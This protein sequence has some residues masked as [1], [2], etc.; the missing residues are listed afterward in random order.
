[1]AVRNRLVLAILC[2]GLIAGWL[3]G[4]GR[5]S[6]TDVRVASAATTIVLTPHLSGLSQPLAMT[7]P[8]DG[9]NR[10]FVVERTG[11]IRVSVNGA[12][13]AT[14]FL[15]VTSLIT[16]SN[17]EQGL[18]G[19]AFHPNY[20]S[21]GLFFVYYTAS[22]GDNTLARFHVS[23]GNA[24]Q[25]DPNSRAVL[26]AEADRFSNHNGGN[27]IFGPDGFL[28]VGLGDG[29]SA[30]DPDNN[31]QNLGVLLGKLL[32]I[33]V[34]S[35]S[36]YAIPSS[37]PF[38]NTPGARGE[39]WALG[40]RN[41]W[42]W[43]FDR[44]AGD[45]MIGD[46]GQGSWE[47]VDR[48]LRNAP[49]GAN[50]QWSCLEGTHPFS[51]RTCDQGTSTGP[52]FEYDHSQGEC[53]VTGGYMYRGSAIP[54]LFGQ[55][56]FS[57]YCSGRIWTLA[58]SGGTWSRMLLLDTP[59]NVASFA[60]DRNGEIY[61]IDITGGTVYRINDGGTPPTNT[62]TP[63]H[64]PV[65]AATN[66]PTRTP[67]PVAA[68]TNTPTRTPTSVAAATNTPTRTP[69][70]VTGGDA[71]SGTI[72][73]DDRPGQ[74]QPLTGEYPAGVVDW[75]SGQW[76]HSGPYAGFSTKSVGFDGSS[77]TS[78]T[79]RFI[80]PR[81][82]VRFD[83][84]NGGTASSALTASCPGQPTL[85]GNASPGQVGTLSTGWTGTCSSVTMTSSNGWD[86]NFDNIVF[87]TPGAAAPTATPTPTAGS[88]PGTTVTF[89]DL[90]SPNR[91]LNG[92]Y[93]SGSI[94][95]G[96]NAWYLSGPWRQFTTNSIG[97]NGSGP[98]SGSFTFVGAVRRLV[99][100]D[101]L[102]GGSGVSTI[103]LSCAG[104]RTASFTLNAGELRTLST[105]WTG[106]CPAVT[107]TSS[108]GW[109]TNF[110]NLVFDTP[111]ADLTITAFN[112][113]NGTTSQPPHLTFTVQNQGTADAGP[114]STFDIHVFADL[115]RPP[116]P[117]DIAYVAHIPVNRLDPGDSATVQGDVFSDTLQPGTHTLWALV[118]G[119]DTVAESNETNNVGS[120]TVTVTQGSSGTQNVTFDDLT[121]PNRPLSGQYPSGVI[122]W[123]TNVWYLSG[124]WRQF[125]TNSIGFNG[126]GP[127]SASF[128]F[129]GSSRRLVQIDAFNGGAVASTVG[130]SCA[131]QATAQFTVAAGQLMTLSTGWT[132]TCTSVT[133]SSTNGWDTN[134]DNLV[135]TQ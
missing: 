19:L 48:Q 65:A 59:Y 93:P 74:D 2:F 78:A 7:Q 124:P 88:A 55:Y 3:L 84:A 15:D 126:S 30:G 28:Y 60:E 117:A 91:A 135:I 129:V 111:N 49:G 86:T 100:I 36:P 22:N 134:F 73:F 25:A 110:D 47:E 89:N 131:G 95:W 40:L 119:H 98:T 43:S 72:S 54:S 96:T 16:S 38:V 34:N 133:V 75:G 58:Q 5:T 85:T 70:P 21:N 44:Q 42:R 69:T 53:S 71:S 31:A 24:N 66:T 122:D 132:G 106:T 87:D 113:T 109:N 20:A 128:T 79:F 62:P 97:F 101:T 90:D 6:D 123:G 27:V 107:V 67:T 64:T 80:T 81:R 37:N 26:F 11:R 68:A 8:N 1:M 94:D 116:T 103:T 76:F 33:D 121:N 4:V 114:G 115:G 9:T 52:I 45:L 56:V 102:N 17:S 46:V 120:V 41:P 35:G 12:L 83:F 61:A 57:D 63:T 29:G 127:T 99:R 39:I 51:S 50:Y 92:Q 104:Q 32:R 18:L 118:D 23:S 14:P 112:A 77:L 13:Q 10:F 82:L 130:L 105:G 108:N 125:T